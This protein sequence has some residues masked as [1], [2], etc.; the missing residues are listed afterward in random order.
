MKK[1]SFTIKCDNCNHKIILKDNV[2]TFYTDIKI[3][4]NRDFSM[5]IECTKCSNIIGTDY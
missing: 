1:Q 3:T 5:D 4:P 2:D